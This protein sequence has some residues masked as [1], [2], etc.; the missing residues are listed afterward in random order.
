[1]AG[2]VHAGP[3]LAK[4][5][6]MFAAR[7]RREAVLVLTIIT[8]VLAIPGCW[9]SG[10]PAE[11]VEPAKPPKPPDPLETVRRLIPI[12]R[13]VRY[14]EVEES[15]GQT[16]TFEVEE[17]WYKQHSD[18]GRDVYELLTTRH[19]PAT[20]ETWSSHQ[21]IMLDSAGLAYFA[22][23]LLE[24]SPLGE[25]VQFDPPMILLP[26]DPAPGTAWVADH[27]KGSRS[28]TRSC[29]LEEASQC[30]GGVVSHCELS[31]S[32]RTTVRDTFCPGVGIVDETLETIDPQRDNLVIS[33]TTTHSYSR[34]L[35]DGGLV[36]AE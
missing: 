31:S 10:P 26:K 33:R 6:H 25:P 12:P 18:R 20:D 16:S 29:R 22:T 30:R 11:Y 17:R 34:E 5:A 28:W 23:P 4:D 13:I 7:W 2:D 19:E 3:A 14:V 32:Y 21:L 15:E 24:D 9:W 36:R 35:E 1:L 27:T 8:A